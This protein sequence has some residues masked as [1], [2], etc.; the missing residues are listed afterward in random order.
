M[1]LNR[2][3]F[4]AGLFIFLLP[5]YVYSE[6]AHDQ[7]KINMQPSNIIVIDPARLQ[8]IGVTYEPARIQTIEKVIRTV[9]RIEADERK[10]AHIH[11]KFDGWIE[12]LLINF[13]GE[14]VKK[15]EALFTVYS[16][17]L[18]STEQEYLLALESK[19]VLGLKAH[20]KAISGASGAFDAAKQR[21]L[22]WGISEK[23]IQRLT[24]TGKVLKI[25][26]IDSPI[27]G[28]VI[29]KTA[30]AGM[31]IEPSGELYTIADLSSLWI[32]GD[33]YEYEL[34]YIHVGQ[35]ADVNL[36][37]LPNEI[38]KAKLDFIYPT[39]DS[40]TRAV[41]VRFQID[42]QNEKFKPG[43][44]ANIDLKI[45]LGKHLVVP[46]DAVLLTGE[47]AVV[48]IYHGDGKIEW[49][50]VTLGARAGNVVEIK[51]GI[52]EDERVITSANF[53]IDSESQLKAAMG[54]M[55]H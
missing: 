33:I 40:Q 49:R 39:V 42:N 48:F 23:E 55:Q 52:H 13:V 24:Q 47:R 34:P 46:K 15:G 4:I 21:L 10:I 17:D 43:M 22:L 45:P 35:I 54:G 3:N 6:T 31:R 44:Y 27:A 38:F 18:V 30:F 2:K 26:T 9:G 12:K 1:I 8:S 14:K 51:S 11:V 16:P 19:K 29:N 20:E 36:S 28:T 7:S 53:L 50:N 32:L 25:I 41:K 37:Y 5:V